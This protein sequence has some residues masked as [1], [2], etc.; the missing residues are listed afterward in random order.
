MGADRDE[1]LVALTDLRRR[2]RHRRPVELDVHLS[3]LGVG[4]TEID[5]A[6]PVAIRVVLEAVPDGVTVTGTIRARWTGPCN[7]CLDPV[8]G[9]LE[10][11][12]QELYADTPDPASDDDVYEL[13][14]EDID[15]RPLVS[16]A[17]LLGLPMLATCP[18]GGVGR[19]PR[20]PDLAVADDDDGEAAEPAGDP[21]WAAL[22]ELDFD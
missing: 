19:C 10:V 20:A 5:P 8:G 4:D 1:L 11:D 3:G 14:R 2:L 16:D 18:Y 12:V 17:L 21:R 6:V 15:L 22:D 13:G 7:L 9:D